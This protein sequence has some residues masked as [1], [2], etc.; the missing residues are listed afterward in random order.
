M[1]SFLDPNGEYTEIGK[2][3]VE[4]SLRAHFPDLIV[5]NSDEKQGSDIPCRYPI[6]EN[7]YLSQ[8]I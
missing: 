6:Q 4:V 3:M 8:T 2:E 1:G 5:R 7:W